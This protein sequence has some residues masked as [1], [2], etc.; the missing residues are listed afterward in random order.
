MICCGNC[1]HFQESYCNL[2]DDLVNPLD[3]C[4]MCDIREDLK[5]D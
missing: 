4:G 1:K 5:E 3:N 2:I